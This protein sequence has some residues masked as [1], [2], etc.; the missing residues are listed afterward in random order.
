MASCLTERAALF[1]GKLALRTSRLRL[2]W[3]R[4]HLLVVFVA[5]FREPLALGEIKGKPGKLATERTSE[6]TNGR[7][8]R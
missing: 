7:T 2:I 6:R 3:Q 4:S 1:T 8:K 5:V